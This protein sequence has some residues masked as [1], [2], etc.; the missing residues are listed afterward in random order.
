[1]R[2]D[3]LHITDV[4]AF[5][6]YLR[7]HAWEVRPGRGDW[8]IAQAKQM[9]KDGWA[10]LYER[11][12]MPE[13]VTVAQPLVSAVFRYYKAKR[14]GW[15]PIT[16]SPIS[17]VPGSAVPRAWQATTA[18]TASPSSANPVE[19]SGSERLRMAAPTGTFTTRFASDTTPSAPRTGTE[20]LAPWDLG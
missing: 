17:W 2:R 12:H 19:I 14:A 3:I 11:A 9:H 8:Q 16:P 1:M 6:A 20:S 5:L 18:R 15:T 13:H 10:V 7:D 4:N